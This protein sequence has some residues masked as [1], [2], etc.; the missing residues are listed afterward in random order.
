MLD[1]IVRALVG[2]DPAHHG[3]IL[4]AVNK[5]GGRD[6][7]AVR[8]RL[9]Q[10]LRDAVYQNALRLSR[11]PHLRH[12]RLYQGKCDDCRGEGCLLR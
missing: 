4:D 7:E 12:P 6:A 8:V 11:P 1:P 3:L 10:A 5:L 9:A 2:V